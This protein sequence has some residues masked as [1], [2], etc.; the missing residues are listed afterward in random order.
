ML[1]PALHGWKWKAYHTQ[2]QPQ[3]KVLPRVPTRV[4]PQQSTR[5][6]TSLCNGKIDEWPSTSATL[7]GERDVCGC[8]LAFLKE[9]CNNYLNNTFGVTGPQGALLYYKNRVQRES[10]GK[11]LKLINSCWG[12]GIGHLALSTRNLCSRLIAP[13]SPI[14][15]SFLI[16]LLANI[17]FLCF[18]VTFANPR[19]KYF[20]DYNHIF[21][22]KLYHFCTDL[23]LQNAKS[24][25]PSPKRKLG[26][27]EAVRSST[28]MLTANELRKM[29]HPV[30]E[31]AKQISML[32]RKPELDEQAV[33]FI[34]KNN[35]E[36][37]MLFDNCSM[38]LKI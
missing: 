15:G 22:A 36:L 33:T 10:C 32:M 11:W 2:L 23:A 5:P 25:L 19:G 9:Q 4:T 1:V 29:S 30:G 34:S 18:P 6:G 24:P 13:L 28:F 8:S 12:E 7:T 21:H 14:P 31:L 37:N 17:N 38:S 26:R 27:R 3:G 16:S 35:L 20:A